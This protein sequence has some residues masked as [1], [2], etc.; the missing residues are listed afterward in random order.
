MAFG[1]VAWPLVVIADSMSAQ[2]IGNIP[3][4]STLRYTSGNPGEANMATEFDLV[5]RGGTLA[6]GTGAALHL[7][8]KS[9]HEC[10]SGHGL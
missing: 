8:G 5:V 3:E 1:I 4:Q 6:D 7:A 2:R 10:G 9:R